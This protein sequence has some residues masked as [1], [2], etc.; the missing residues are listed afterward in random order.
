[1]STK[2]KPN[3]VR[4]GIVRFSYAQVFTPRSMD[5]KNE[6]APKK[7]SC[8]L[9]IKK[10]DKALIKLIKAGIEAAIEIGLE[11]MWNK[12]MP[13]Q[14]AKP[15]QDGDDKDNDPD[16][17]YAG[18]WYLNAKATQKPGIVDKNGDR[19]TDED[20]FYSGCYGRFH[21]TMFPYSHPTGGK[22]I[23]VALNHLQKT[24]DG[25]RLAGRIS[26]EDA[27]DDDWSDDEEDDD[28][29]LID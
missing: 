12:K 3:D 9:L 4:G 29:D 27:F 11:K 10:S 1:M 23:G 21:I 17:V 22:G 8:V 6:N 14:L 5:P 26:V 19:I 20:E 7:Y 28:D 16:G 13:K 24:K 15:L 2:L 18:H 25:E